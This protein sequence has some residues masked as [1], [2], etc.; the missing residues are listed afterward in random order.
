LRTQYPSG[1]GLRRA[2]SGGHAQEAQKAQ[3]LEQK[4]TEKTKESIPKTLR[5]IRVYLSL[6]VVELLRSLCSF[7]ADS[8]RGFSGFEKR[9]HGRRSP[10]CF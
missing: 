7:A 2:K 6:S 8:L 1:A 5:D 9:R 10:N 4:A 3:K